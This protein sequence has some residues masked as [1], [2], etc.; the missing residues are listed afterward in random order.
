ML[1]QC[2]EN[3]AQTGKHVGRRYPGPDRIFASPQ[4]VIRR[5][6]YAMIK[7]AFDQS[8]IKFA[9]PTVQ[10]AGGQEAQLAAAQEALKVL[11]PPPAA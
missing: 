5:R 11:K 2:E 9:Y 8:G 10:V 6:A 3:R 4:F 1:E 7:A